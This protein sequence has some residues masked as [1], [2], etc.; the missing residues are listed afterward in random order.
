MLTSHHL[1]IMTP[2]LHVGVHPSHARAMLFWLLSL[3]APGIYMV[4][5]LGLLG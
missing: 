2:F 3:E 1:T 4:T 5:Y